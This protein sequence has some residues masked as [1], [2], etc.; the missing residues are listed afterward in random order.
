M[1]RCRWGTARTASFTGR[2]TDRI[3]EA[4]AKFLGA[5]PIK[6]TSPN[7]VS[8]ALLTQLSH[9]ASRSEE[10][11]HANSSCPEP[12]HCRCARHQSEV[13]DLRQGIPLSCTL[14]PTTEPFPVQNARR[15]TSRR[16]RSQRQE[17]LGQ[18]SK[19]PVE[20]ILPE[21][22]LVLIDIRFIVLASRRRAC[23][24][25]GRSTWQSDSRSRAVLSRQHSRRSRIG[26]TGRVILFL[27]PAEREFFSSL[28][29]LP[30]HR[31]C[32]P[33]PTPAGEDAGLIQT[34][35]NG[36]GGGLHQ[37]G[38]CLEMIHNLPQDLNLLV[39]TLH[40]WSGI[41]TLDPACHGG[42]G[43]RA[44]GAGPYQ[45]FRPFQGKAHENR[46]D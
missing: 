3:A 8:P 10:R 31:R 26:R 38:T 14:G 11:D 40:R 39:D 24:H 45:G 21:Q 9:R 5:S 15:S 29:P 16:R 22:P 28:L 17:A 32:S 41:G 4:G 12:R 23:T 20:R 1:G 43:R 2:R 18:G 37:A 19:H 27:A 13:Q 42:D 7:V 25:L 33:R 34:V 35:S 46:P 6:A 30:T 44:V 36:L